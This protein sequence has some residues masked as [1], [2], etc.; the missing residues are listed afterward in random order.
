MSTRSS[1]EKNVNVAVETMKRDKIKNQH[2]TLRIYL[3]VTKTNRKSGSSKNDVPFKL[4]EIPFTHPSISHINPRKKWEDIK[5]CIID[6]V[7][8]TKFTAKFSKGV[9]SYV[10]DEDRGI[11]GWTGKRSKNQLART[12]LR[13]KALVEIQDK[14]Q[15]LSHFNNYRCK[16]KDNNGEKLLIMDLGIS[17]YDETKENDA[18]LASMTKLA[19]KKRKNQLTAEVTPIPAKKNKTDSKSTGNFF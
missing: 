16:C 10:F 8:S 13:G 1:S 18:L 14:K 3:H 6:A 4:N 9:E 19:S 17:V 15:W 7:E 12:Q 2:L 5:E 11:I